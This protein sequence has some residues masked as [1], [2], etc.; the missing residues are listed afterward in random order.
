M[1][2]LRRL[3]FIDANLPPGVHVLVQRPFLL[4]GK[5]LDAQSRPL[6]WI[7]QDLDLLLSPLG[8]HRHGQVLQQVAPAE[9]IRKTPVTLR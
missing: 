9:L 4:S 8:R 2:R 5:R 3:V 7:F 6:V 1:P